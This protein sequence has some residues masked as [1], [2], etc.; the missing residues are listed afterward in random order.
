MRNRRR[1][2][3]SKP[4]I[5]FLKAGNSLA[6]I[7]RSDAVLGLLESKLQ[8]TEKKFLYGKERYTRGKR[9]EF[10][11][12]DCFTYDLKGRL[13]CPYGFYERLASCLEDRGY[14]VVIE[15]LRPHERP[16]I[17]EPNWD[18]VLDFAKLRY[19]Q[20]EMLVQIL[21]N[22]CGQISCPPG[23][24][25][26]FAIA[27]LTKALPKARIDIIA[28]D[29]DVVRNIY[30]DLVGMIP[31]VG[32][33]MAS[34]N[35]VD[36]RVMVYSAS[37]LHHS[38]FDADVVL[39]DEVHKLAADKYIPNLVRYRRSR[40]FGFSATLDMRL[41]NKDMR[42]EG[43]FGPL[44]YKVS[45][46]AAVKHGLIVPIE[47]HWRNVIMDV[48]PCAD[49]S[50]ETRTRWGIWRNRFR[51]RLIAGDAKAAGKDQQVLI[52]VRTID[53][54]VHL[55]R[56]LPEFTLMYAENNLGYAERDT[57]VRRGLI[58]DEEPWMTLDRR[59]RL[60]EQFESGELRKVIAT[61]VWDQGVNFHNLSV[62]IRADASA[63]PTLDTQ[64]PGRTSRLS[65]GKERGIIIDY[66]D[67]FNLGFAR[68]AK[69][70]WS[71]YAA[72]GW[73]QYLPEA[74][75]GLLQKQLFA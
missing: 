56:E 38:R 27:L 68:R 47:V 63:S 2:F 21:A 7:S 58:M 43:I 39:G 10:T 65:T 49:H 25:K 23:Y 54:A 70:R 52:V 33:I 32:I 9:I 44:I 22:T 69:K 19:G 36:K 8:Y 51:N 28:P 17:F 14:R 13:V 26:S 55:K 37:S 50:E 31:S 20:G 62:L 30:K 12:R 42:V 57:Y 67:Q 1:S 16:E 4:T 18:N 74:P 48:D 64:I 72:N 71:S 61:S 11:E 45:Y 29:A 5:R 73:K 46:S 35:V 59:K 6:V 66:L 15:D 75:A 60:K 34:Q 41:D 3:E 53:H 24:G 40:N